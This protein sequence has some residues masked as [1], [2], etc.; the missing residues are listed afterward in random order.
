MKKTTKRVIQIQYL[1]AFQPAIYW[2]RHFIY[3]FIDKILSVFLKRLS[4]SLNF[5]FGIIYFKKHHTNDDDNC[6]IT[7]ILE[8]NINI[9]AISHL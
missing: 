2:N 9:A 6:H 4:R 1:F 3:L 5:I 8:W 7:A